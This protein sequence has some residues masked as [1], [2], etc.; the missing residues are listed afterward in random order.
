ME[1]SIP[2]DVIS[3]IDPQPITWIKQQRIKPASPIWCTSNVSLLNRVSSLNLNIQHEYRSKHR[4]NSGH[5][6]VKRLCDLGYTDIHLWG[7]DSVWSQD[8]SSTMDDRIPRS[9]RKPTLKQDWH[10]HWRELHQTYT[11]VEFTVHCPAHRTYLNDETRFK[12]H[13][14]L[15]ISYQPDRISV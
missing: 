11:D 12:W 7:F 15:D 9:H 14:H 10:Q 8:L 3:I 2:H 1:W 5:Q 6:A 4:M 13:T